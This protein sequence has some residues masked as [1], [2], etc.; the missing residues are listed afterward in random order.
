MG[1]AG[2][3]LCLGG[4]GRSQQR[5]G[6]PAVGSEALGL[7][8]PADKNAGQGGTMSS[9]PGAWGDSGYGLGKCLLNE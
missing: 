9:A 6:Q 8:P 3:A 1:L 5:G 7:S 2:E 4:P